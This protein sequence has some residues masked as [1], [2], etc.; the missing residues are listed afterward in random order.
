MEHP[1]YPD[2]TMPY[3]QKRSKAYPWGDGD[4]PL[5]A[6]LFGYPHGHPKAGEHH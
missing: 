4:T 3:M 1:V 6:H 2:K 5:F